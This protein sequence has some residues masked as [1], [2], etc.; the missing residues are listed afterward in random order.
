MISIILSSM[1][2]FATIE[3]YSEVE[4]MALNVYHEARGE[5]YKGKLAVANVTLNRVKHKGFPNTI[6][7]VV[8]DH[9]QFSWYSD[10]MSDKVILNNKEDTIAWEDSVTASLEV[11]ERY[12]SDPTRGATHYY[13]HHKVTP[14]WAG[15]FEH[16]FILG[17]HT[18]LR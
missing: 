4:C 17:N 8:K 12:V 18:F 3:P 5:S 2:A 9:K 16:K 1:L 6:C 13:A 14:Y 11:I 10:G 15:S 7:G